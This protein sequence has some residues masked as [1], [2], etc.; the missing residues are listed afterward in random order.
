VTKDYPLILC[1][2]TSFFV[3]VR[4]IFSPEY[5]DRLCIA[6]TPIMLIGMCAFANRWDDA[7]HGFSSVVWFAITLAL[8]TLR[9]MRTALNRLSILLV[10]HISVLL[11]L[12][13]S[14]FFAISQWFSFGNRQGGAPPWSLCSDDVLN[15][16]NRSKGSSS[17]VQ[18]WLNKLGAIFV[19]FH[20]TFVSLYCA[21]AKPHPFRLTPIYASSLAFHKQTPKV[22]SG[23]TR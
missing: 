21:L 19:F 6:H 5:A 20:D 7:A 13:N 4:R 23:V 16:V 11:R 2:L 3:F 18:G 22:R 8:S 10:Q 17:P 9:E 12:K 14:L 1:S 15:F